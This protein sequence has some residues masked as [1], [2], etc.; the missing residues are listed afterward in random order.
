MVM[1][2]SPEHDAVRI[3]EGQHGAH[4]GQHCE[5]STPKLKCETFFAGK[6]VVIVHY[7]LTTHC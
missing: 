1:G 4:E 3:L 7:V 2:Q 5:A 6:T